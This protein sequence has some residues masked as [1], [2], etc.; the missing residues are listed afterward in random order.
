MGKRCLDQG[1]T[2]V[3]PA[4][5]DPF[6]IDQNGMVIKMKVKD[7]IPYM[8]IDQ[9]K[10][11]GGHEN[12]RKL[13]N[14]LDDDCSTSEGEGTI[15]LDGESGEEMIENPSGKVK[16]KMLTKKVGRKRKPRRRKPKVSE[17]AV[18]SDVEEC[19]EVVDDDSDEE[20]ET[21]YGLSDT[22]EMPDVG[23]DIEVDNQDW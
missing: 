20:A 8:S 6:M 18:G 22:E 10:E 12:V 11:Y 14:V 21:R 23:Q 15:I 13:L 4:G 2:F 5:K 19:H 16:I 9:V 1:Y 7:H 3:W 17:V